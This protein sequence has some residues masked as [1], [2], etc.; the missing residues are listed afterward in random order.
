MTAWP[1]EPM[2]DFAKTPVSEGE[3]GIFPRNCPQEELV[4]ALANLIMNRRQEA[5]A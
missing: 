5:V 3:D 2:Q 1:A 4:I